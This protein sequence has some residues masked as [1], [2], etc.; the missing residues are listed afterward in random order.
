VFVVCF[1]GRFL[2]NRPIHA[3][4]ISFWLTNGRIVSFHTKQKMVRSYHNVVFLLNPAT[5]CL[6]TERQNAFFGGFHVKPLFVLCKV[7]RGIEEKM[8]SQ[9]EL[10][11]FHLQQLS[12]PTP[13]LRLICKEDHLL[14]TD[15]VD[16]IGSDICRAEAG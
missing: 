15:I 6:L 3:I 9:K 2:S 5:R 13:S 8:G 4:T 7:V 10:Q 16:C 12:I 14:A 11:L 1:H